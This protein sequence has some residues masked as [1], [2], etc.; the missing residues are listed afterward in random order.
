[1]YSAIEKLDPKSRAKLLHKKI[2]H[3][4]KEVLLHWSKLYNL[5]PELSNSDFDEFTK[6][7][8]EQCQLGD[9]KAHPVH[10][11]SD[12]QY[13][14][15]RLL[16]RWHIDGMGWFSLTIEGRSKQEQ[17]QQFRSLGGFEYVLVVTDEV[18]HMV[19]VFPLKHK[20]EAFDKLKSLILKV[21]VETNLKLVEL[22]GDLAG[23]FISEQLKKFLNENGTKLTS[24]ES[25]VSQYN[26][27]AERM[28]RTLQSMTRIMMVQAGA[29]QILWDEA[30][31]WASHVYNSTPQKVVKWRCPFEKFNPRYKHNPKRLLVWGCNVIAKLLDKNRGKFEPKGFRGMFMGHDQQTGAQRVLDLQSGRV[32]V[33]RSLVA[34]ESDFSYMRQFAKDWDPNAAVTDAW[35]D[36]NPFEQLQ[37]SKDEIDDPDYESK[38]DSDVRTSGEVVSEAEAESTSAVQSH[39]PKS[40]FNDLR[41]M[42]ESR[43]R[44][45]R[46][47]RPPQGN[48]GID[49]RNYYDGDL[50]KIFKAVETAED[51]MFQQ[52]E[53][54]FSAIEIQIINEVLLA[55]YVKSVSG[56][57]EPK[58]YKE[59]MAID[60]NSWKPAFDSEH[61]SI[62]DLEVYTLMKLP[63]EKKAIPTRWVTKI[64][65][66]ENNKPIKW[67]ARFVVKGFAQIPGVDYDL[68]QSPVASWKSIRTIM[69]ITAKENNELFQF[70]YDTAFL[71]AKLT[72]DIYVE[73]PEGYH[74]GEPDMVWKLNKALYGLK[75][76]PREWNKT[77][78]KFMKELGFKALVS[79]PCVYIKKSKTDRRI[80]IGLY[81]DDTIIS[82]HKE[83]LMEWESDKQRI[84]ATFP[85]KDLGEC[86]WILNVKVTRDRKNRTITLSQQA[87]AD[88]IAAEHG[89]DRTR[90]VSTPIR[91]EDLYLNDKEKSKTLNKQEHKKYQSI[92]GELLY[93]ANITRPD[94]SFAVGRLC[95]RV[96]NPEEHHLAAAKRVMRYLGQTSHFSLVFGSNK[97]DTGNF[98]NY[99]LL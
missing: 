78:D 4:G 73:Q 81:V 1:V 22:H 19:W 90:T 67:K 54:A 92:V 30:I 51:S 87:Y 61:K 71:N 82:V 44:S 10:K 3:Q 48:I 9:I 56:I 74:V 83:D 36:N 84:G 5:L 89:L 53:I 15:D 21:Q 98:R 46:V 26:G 28:N 18:T 94:L 11:Q 8:C 34:H 14:A 62:T 24:A 16:G 12:P 70:D 52:E 7:N 33:T 31:C 6:L 75:Q 93:A 45:G 49:H 72:E 63:K 20:D 57:R 40:V 25:G 43:T 95:Q 69:S 29:P 79:D 55:A 42:G 17:R 39:K 80:L 23:E 13:K 59:A 97:I 76:A 38:Y 41:E 85:I 32:V 2:G 27:V 68:T 58:T 77:A 96:S 65:L 37:E 64:K 50:E 99:C 47:S 35:S 91:I 88:R 60:P 86:H 66:D